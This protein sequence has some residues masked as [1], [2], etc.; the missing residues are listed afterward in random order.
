MQNFLDQKGFCV[1]DPDFISDA[2]DEVLSEYRPAVLEVITVP[3]M[4]TYTGGIRVGAIKRH[5][6]F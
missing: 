6:Y 2:C 5:F 4:Y 1:D 3:P